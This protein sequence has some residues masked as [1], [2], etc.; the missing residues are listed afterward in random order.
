M[1]ALIDTRK[2]NISNLF[3][4]FINDNDNDNDNVDLCQQCFKNS[5]IINNIYCISCVQYILPSNSYL[6]ND[7]SLE[8]QMNMDI[9]LK[10]LKNAPMPNNGYCITC[11]QCDKCAT[12]LAILDSECPQCAYLAS[13][14]PIVI[15]DSIQIHI[16]TNDNF[17]NQYQPYSRPLNPY[18]PDLLISDPSTKIYSPTKLNETKIINKNKS[19]KTSNK[20]ISNSFN[21]IKLSEIK[22]SNN[23][24][25]TTSNKLIDNS[26]SN[27]RGLSDTIKC[28]IVPKVIL[29]YILMKFCDPQSIKNIILNVGLMNVLDTFCKKMLTKAN[30]GFLWNC[31]NGHLDIVKWLYS[32]GRF[33]IHANNEYAFRIACENG[34][35]DVA[36]WLYYYFD[37]DRVNIHADNEYAFRIACANGHLYVSQWLY[38]LGQVNIH[39]DNEYAFRSS[40]ANGHLIVAKW[41]YSLGQVN[42]HADNEYAFRSSC[43]NGHLTVAKWLYSLGVNIHAN[44]EQAFQSSCQNGHLVVKQWLCSIDI[45]NIYANDN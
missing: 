19:T 2:N 36:K 7:K 22:I 11:M 34:H 26:S 9:C 15:V 23:N 37:F 24:K 44:N 10:C 45:I 28:L 38:S 8:A 13:V 40:C 14:K 29:R 18:I 41:L 4:N 17:M 39:V 31:R 6:P 5:P 33:N 25:S 27:N 30:H 20:L 21:P 32:L 42:I 43:A 35:L 1:K 3:N 12:I 16:P